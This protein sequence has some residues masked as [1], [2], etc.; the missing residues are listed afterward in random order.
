MQNRISDHLHGPCYR[1]KASN[2]V[3]VYWKW[4]TANK[5]MWVIWVFYSCLFCFQFRYK[6]TPIIINSLQFTQVLFVINFF[7]EK[8][9]FIIFQGNLNLCSQ[10]QGY[11][12]SNKHQNI[13]WK[14]DKF[15]FST[16]LS[17][18]YSRTSYKWTKNWAMRPIIRGTNIFHEFVSIWRTLRM[19][20][21]EDHTHQ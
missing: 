16:M 20:S 15:H 13:P 12:S 8:I 14:E 18:L 11:R 4:L 17:D 2:N 1:S 7:K 21:H 3:C 6:S 5:N 9:Q 10:K 19:T